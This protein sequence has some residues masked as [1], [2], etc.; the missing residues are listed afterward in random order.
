MNPRQRQGACERPPYNWVGP[1]SVVDLVW[2]FRV[3][4]ILGEGVVHVLLPLPAL[5]HVWSSATAQPYTHTRMCSVRRDDKPLAE[6]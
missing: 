2:Q 3:E 1:A 6:R 5:A 4:R